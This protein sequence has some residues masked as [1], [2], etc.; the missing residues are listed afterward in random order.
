MHIL[1]ALK[2]QSTGKQQQNSLHFVCFKSNFGS[3]WQPFLA[4]NKLPVI[5]LITTKPEKV[6]KH[7]YI[8]DFKKY[9]TAQYHSSALLPSAWVQ[10]WPAM[11]IPTYL[12]DLYTTLMLMKQVLL[13]FPQCCNFLQ[14]LLLSNWQLII[15]FL[16]ATLFPK[17]MF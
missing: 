16:A 8:V 3:F 2:I 14:P 5:F 11:S 12:P 10:M 4:Q 7:M 15:C 1:T 13:L 9:E 6:R 17:C